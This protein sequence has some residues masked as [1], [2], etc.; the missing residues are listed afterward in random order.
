MLLILKKSR[1]YV[2]IEKLIF[3][4]SVFVSANWKGGK[5]NITGLLARCAV[6]LQKSSYWLYDK[7]SKKSWCG[8]WGRFRCTCFQR[9]CNYDLPLKLL[10]SP[11][12]SSSCPATQ[13][14]AQSHHAPLL[15]PIGWLRNVRTVT[16]T[17]PYSPALWGSITVC[18]SICEPKVLGF[19][20]TSEAT[21]SK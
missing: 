7:C 9:S 1:L 2:G 12:H 6:C 14:T 18:I 8:I 5:P 15:S 11:H 3:S 20:G 16:L 4:L 19:M 21:P 10:M 17:V 13:H